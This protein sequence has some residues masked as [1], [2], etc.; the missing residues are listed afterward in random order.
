MENAAGNLYCT[1]HKHANSKVQKLPSQLRFL[2]LSIMITIQSSRRVK[3]T[4]D[5]YKLMLGTS[6][7]NCTTSEILEFA[8]PVA[9]PLELPDCFAT[10][11]AKVHY[12]HYRCHSVTKMLL[13]FTMQQEK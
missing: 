11:E 7:Y 1:F 12:R 5:E 4:V 13:L 8:Q 9:E 6:L 2:L 3:V 10:T